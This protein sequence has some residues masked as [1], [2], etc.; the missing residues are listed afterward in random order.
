[1]PGVDDPARVRKLLQGTAKL[2]FFQCYENKE[3]KD[4]FDRMNVCLR[5]LNSN[6]SDTALTKDTSSNAQKARQFYDSLPLF[7]YLQPNA[8]DKGELGKGPI[9]GYTAIKDTARLNAYFATVKSAGAVPAD[10]AFLYDAKPL[11]NS[12]SIIQVYAIKTG[13][14]GEALLTGEKV[15]DAYK[16]LNQTGAIEVGMTMNAEGARDWARITA[17]NVGKCIAIVLDEVVYT[18]PVINGEI[19]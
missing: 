15:I 3:F 16:D 13:R 9:I 8:S 1:M 12:P 19:T 4:Y 11:K 7:K 17:A 6:A 14:D 10:M 5:N 18:A 2:E